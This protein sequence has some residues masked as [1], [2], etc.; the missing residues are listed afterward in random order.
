MSGDLEQVA[1]Q[2]AEAVIELTEESSGGQADSLK[3]LERIHNDLKVIAEI[4]ETNEDFSLVLNHPNLSMEDKKELLLKIFKG[5]VDDTTLR[6]LELLSERRRLELLPYLEKPFKTILRERMN[7]VGG[8][9]ISAQ[10]LSDGQVQDIKARLTKH[11]GKRLELEVSVDPS[12]IGGMILKLGDQVI[13][14]SLRG[15]LQV[16]EKSLLSV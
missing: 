6:L 7:V 8:E 3:K 5:R 11:L 13:D 2:Y 10:K 15:K 14:G 4:F 1:S 16:V 12:L 9:L